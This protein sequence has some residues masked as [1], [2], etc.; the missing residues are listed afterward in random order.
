MPLIQIDG[1]FYIYI[2]SM[3]ITVSSVRWN[4]YVNKKHERK[5][6]TMLQIREIGNKKFCGF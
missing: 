6:D 2:F 1:A 3:I 5:K 4:T